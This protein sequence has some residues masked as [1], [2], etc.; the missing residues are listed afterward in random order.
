[1][2][3]KKEILTLNR[4]ISKAENLPIFQLAKIIATNVTKSPIFLTN[5]TKSL[6]NQ[7]F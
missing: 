2:N 6:K 5:L 1:M 7:I 4:L 3:Y